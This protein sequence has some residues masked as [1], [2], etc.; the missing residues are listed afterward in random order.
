MYHLTHV[1]I[2]LSASINSFLNKRR[3]M[4]EHLRMGQLHVSKFQLKMEL[5]QCSIASNYTEFFPVILSCE[6]WPF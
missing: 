2:V 3:R 1:A 6:C 5:Q 4:Y